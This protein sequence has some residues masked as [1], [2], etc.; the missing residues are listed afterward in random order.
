MVGSSLPVT[1]ASSGV[2]TVSAAEATFVSFAAS[3]SRLPTLLSQLPAAA[4]LLPAVPERARTSRA[5]SPFLLEMRSQSAVTVAPKA[6]S[7][8]HAEFCRLVPNSTAGIKAQANSWTRCG[9]RD[10]G[11]QMNPVQLHLFLQHDQS[12]LQVIS[13][14]YR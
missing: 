7:R 14:G 13:A 1:G 8:K 2:A 9:Q 5:A 3:F 11:Q 4:P 12:K 10:T 6:A